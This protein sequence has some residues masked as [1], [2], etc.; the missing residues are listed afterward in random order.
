MRHMSHV[1]HMRSACSLLMIRSYH[2]LMW[3]QF[4]L[5]HS[6]PPLFASMIDGASHGSHV[7]HMQQAAAELLQPLSDITA[8]A[9][10]HT[11]IAVVAALPADAPPLSPTLFIKEKTAAATPLPVRIQPTKLWRAPAAATSDTSSIMSTKLETA[12]AA[13]APRLTPGLS[14]G[15]SSWNDSR[16]GV[17]S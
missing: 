7:T 17:N 12:V 16:C 2:L 10:S 4:V 15:Q 11:T 9:L 1:G 3:Q 14:T 8:A 13:V 5:P 6:Q